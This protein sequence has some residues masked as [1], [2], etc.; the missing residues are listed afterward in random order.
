MRI[1]TRLGKEWYRRG[2]G[3]IRRQADSA[4]EAP[5]SYWVVIARWFIIL[6]EFFHFLFLNELNVGLHDRFLVGIVF[7]SFRCEA[8]FGSFPYNPLLPFVV[9]RVASTTSQ[10]VAAALSSICNNKPD[11]L[12]TRSAMAT[13]SLTR[14]CL[15]LSSL[16]SSPCLPASFLYGHPSPTQLMAGG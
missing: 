3:Q 1:R 6:S 2:W 16:R 4:A 13:K 8:I 9:M 14:A 10:N 5:S 7:L 15:C 12:S 11:V